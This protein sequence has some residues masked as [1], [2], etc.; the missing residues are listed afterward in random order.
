MF[1]VYIIC[2]SKKKKM[3]EGTLVS[4]VLTNSTFQF[5]FKAAALPKKNPRL[6]FTMGNTTAAILNVNQ[7]IKI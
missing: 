5:E 3:K 2:S 1:Y 7:E 4:W 6:L